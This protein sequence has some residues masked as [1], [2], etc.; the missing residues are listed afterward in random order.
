[1]LLGA[2]LPENGAGNLD[3]LLGTEGISTDGPVV[4]LT[5]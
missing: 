2:R 4:T 3:D 5:A 1:M